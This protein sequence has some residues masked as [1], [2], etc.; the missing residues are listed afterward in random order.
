VTALRDAEAELEIAARIQAAQAASLRRMPHDA[1]L[2]QAAQAICDELVALPFIDVAGVEA[3][4]NGKHVRIV[5]LSAPDWLPIKAGDQ[6]PPELALP[7]REQASDT[8]W[9]I[10]VTP[11][12]A[13][14]FR[15]V[16]AAHG[17]KALAYGPLLHGGHL[18]GGLIIATSD[19][20]FART[21]VDEL[22][23]GVG[24]SAT[25]T[26]LLVERLHTRRRE[27]E[28]RETLEVVLATRAFQPIFQPIVDLAS[29]EVVGYEA[30]T[31]FTSGQAP[32]HCFADAWS[33]GLGPEL[34]LATLEA[35][36][37]AA[38][39]L[40][41][42]RWLDLNVSPRLLLEP[43][44]V[45]ELLRACERSLILEVTEHEPVADYATLREAIASLGPDI[46]VAVDDA[47]AG[48]ANFVHIIEL[49]ADLVKLDISLVRGVNDD[50]G[51]QAMVVGMRHFSQTAGCRL[52]A[53]GIETKAEARTLAG[54]GVEFGQG[55]LF[56]RPEPAEAF[57]A[58]ARA[59]PRS[60][61]RVAATG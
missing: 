45:C 48:A 38:P 42:R 34:E 27:Q 54:L 20:R 56:G 55:Y 10:A 23:G 61:R 37:D 12:P 17:I 24:F 30:L 9:A 51:R 18:D 5:G 40:P 60:V 6:L 36:M 49:R 7:Q 2:E 31:R 32:D 46:R 26:A 13:T 19:E 58:P 41:A 33:V 8:S 57:V 43:D 28:L 29:G 52:V 22:A 50:L 59:Q 53:E 47:G 15:A 35:A 4:V 44:R 25:T 39:R 11:E 3:F 1:T 16:L 21:L 14:P